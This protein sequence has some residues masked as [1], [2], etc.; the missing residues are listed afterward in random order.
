MPQKELIKKT[1]PS[2]KKNGIENKENN[3]NKARGFLSK[4][5]SKYFK[6]KELSI[7]IGMLIASN[8]AYIAIAYFFPV[9]G[10][11]SFVWIYW[12]LFGVVRGMIIVGIGY[13]FLSILFPKA[14]TYIE[15]KLFNNETEK[16]TPWQRL[17]FYTFLYC[18]FI[19]VLLIS[20]I[21]MGL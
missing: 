11:P 4:L 3:K 13:M 2:H 5:F 6:I 19:V 16:I 8:Y 12:L 17:K 10:E 14:F 15:D 21:T 9:V 20:V 18:F 1:F 7:T